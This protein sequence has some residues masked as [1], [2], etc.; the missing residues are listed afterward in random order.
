MLEAAMSGNAQNFDERIGR[1][2]RKHRAMS[3]GY[4]FRVDKNG[5]IN[6]KPKRAKGSSPFTMLIALLAVGLLF[7]GVALA[8]FGP[9]K[10]AERL[11]PMQSGNMVEQAGA[12]ILEPGP[13]TEWVAHAVSDVVR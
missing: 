13:M 2:T 9:E 4:T 5:L 8:N 1:V 11:A 3:K 12:W 6:I 10:Y 7:K